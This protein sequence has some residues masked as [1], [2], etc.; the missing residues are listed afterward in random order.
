[1]FTVT[2]NDR[3]DKKSNLLNRLFRGLFVIPGIWRTLDDFSSG[4]VC[5]LLVLDKYD[6]RDCFK[7]YREFISLNK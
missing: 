4:L 1:M 5:L 2:L 6:E 7:S 3:R